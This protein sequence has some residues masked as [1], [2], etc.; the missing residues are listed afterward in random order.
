[1]VQGAQLARELFQAAVRPIM[2][3]SFSRVDHLAARLGSGSEVLGVDD[4][5]ST[6]HDF[7]CRLTLLV[8]DRDGDAIPDIDRTLQARLPESVRGW[9]VRFATTWDG[10]HHHRV[11]VAT[12]HD[13]ARS[14]LGF[15]T[16]EPLSPAAWLCLT[17]QSILEVVGGPVFHDTTRS[18]RPLSE[19]LEW[20]PDDLWLYT[21]SSGW[22]RLSQELPFVGR[23]GAR[24]DEIGSRVL[25]ARLTSGIIYLAFLLA[26]T[27]M[28]YP[29][30]TGTVLRELPGAP[31][32]V[33]SLTSAT[34][35]A[36]WSTRQEHLGAA[37]EGL[38]DRQRGVGLP[39]VEPAVHQFFERPFLGVDEQVAGTLTA[40]I[41][42]P[43]IRRLPP[44]GSI[45]QWSDNVDLLANPAR[46]AAATAL[47]EVDD[48]TPARPS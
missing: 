11:E 33:G 4:E 29:K 8:D 35:A 38:A 24:G 27:W 21:L 3:E 1:M 14:R 20:Y 5:Q 39:A 42:D 43:E 18:F 23:T 48:P 22:A 40:Q 34:T 13:F 30:W 31:N 44:I 9:P 37:I 17:G 2:E 15:D 26:R 10:R 46:R 47:Y 19:R 28:P 12:V 41:H 16:R 32:I 36:T 45:E 7:G 25:T 6:D